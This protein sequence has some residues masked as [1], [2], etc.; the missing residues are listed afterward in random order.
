MELALL[1]PNIFGRV[2]TVNLNVHP[3]SCL[4]NLALSGLHLKWQPAR[5]ISFSALCLFRDRHFGFG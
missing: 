3:A 5:F 1:N 4:L 2:L